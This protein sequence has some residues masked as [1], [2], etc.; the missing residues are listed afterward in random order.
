MNIEYTPIYPVFPLCDVERPNYRED[1]Y[2]FHSEQDMGAHIPYCRK[3]REYGYCPCSEDCKNYISKQE[4]S[5]IVANYV[6]EK[7]EENK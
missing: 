2:Y 3:E 5:R 4:V 7:K 6:D 1:C